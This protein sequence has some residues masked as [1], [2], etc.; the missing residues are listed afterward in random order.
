MSVGGGTMK[1]H[2]VVIALVAVI[3]ALLLYIREDWRQHR[4]ACYASRA[5][6]YHLTAIMH[7]RTQAEVSE[8]ASA[9]VDTQYMVDWAC[10]GKTG[11]ETLPLGTRLRKMITGQA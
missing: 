5:H 1:R 11:E 6:L 3:V 10:D 8:N 7:G 9:L 2:S 4:M